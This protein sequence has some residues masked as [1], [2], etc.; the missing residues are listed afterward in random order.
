MAR[1][2]K[3]DSGDRRITAIDGLRGALIAYIVLHHASDMAP[4]A[5]WSAV[6]G[7]GGAAVDVFFFLS[8]FVLMLSFLRRRSRFDGGVPQFLGR[9]LLRLLPM[10]YAG[11]VFSAIVAVVLPFHMEHGGIL[12]HEPLTWRALAVHLL[13]MQNFFPQF[14]KLVNGN[15]WFFAVEIQLSLVF[16]LLALAWRRWGGRAVLMTCAFLVVLSFAVFG[17]AEYYA[18]P[19]FLLLFAMGMAAAE[20]HGAA[21]RSSSFWW[22]AWWTSLAAGGACALGIA[23]PRLAGIQPTPV[24][25]FLADVVVGCAAFATVMLGAPPR[26]TILR[27]ALETKALV[28]LGLLSYALYLLHSPV[29]RFLHVHFLLPI[30]LGLDAQF[31]ILIILGSAA[32]LLLAAPFRWAFEAPVMPPPS[33]VPTAPVR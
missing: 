13:A 32:T 31:A 18:K 4:V 27:R 28:R 33:P 15:Y 11:L 5:P 9:R 19:Q 14:L 24:L 12:F 7:A 23:M 8:G 6:L 1:N 10:Y 29:L 30:G 16:P 20:A 25:L 3:P 21:A 17:P 22:I 2:V 26:V